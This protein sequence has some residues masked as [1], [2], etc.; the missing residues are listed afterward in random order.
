[1]RFGYYSERK[2]FSKG[3]VLAVE[4][5]HRLQPF[6]TN[7]GFAVLGQ[8]FQASGTDP[9]KP[10]SIM[11]SSSPRTLNDHNQLKTSDNPRPNSSQSCC[12]KSSHAILEMLRLYKRCL[13]C[14]QGCGWVCHIQGR[15]GTSFPNHAEYGLQLRGVSKAGKQN[16]P[17]LVQCKT[18]VGGF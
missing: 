8:A 3:A 17:C 18:R 11:R 10:P 15:T 2:I 14:L 1:M 7:L 6:Q 13:F 4:L 12:H 5:R 9:K 16:F